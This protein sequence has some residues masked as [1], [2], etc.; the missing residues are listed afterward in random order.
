MQRYSL[1]FL[2]TW[3]LLLTIGC[4][5]SASNDYFP[6]REGKNWTYLLTTTY[7]EETLRE[8]VTLE[9]LGEIS[10]T[11]KTYHVRRSSHGIDYYL[12][13]D[14]TGIYRSALRTLV[15]LKPRLDT[16]QRFVLKYPL[17]K[18]TNWQQITR[19]MILMRVFP[20]TH[21]AKSA[22]VPMI[23]EIMSTDESVTVPAGT[24]EHCIKVVGEGETEIYTD[25]VNGYTRI[26]FKVEEWY[27]PGVGLVKQVRYE[28]DGESISVAKTPIFLGGNKRLELIAMDD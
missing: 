16:N 26:P 13:R 19:P 15:E 8:T 25:G 12:N 4:E 10:I 11:D 20:N 9:N 21:L 23:F 14:E 3:I 1:L 17:S 7:P 24:F 27:A 5:H 2:F 6:L 22:Q 28:L 18:G